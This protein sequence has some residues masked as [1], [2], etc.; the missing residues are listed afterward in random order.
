MN[1]QQ[2][3]S[4]VFNPRRASENR[5]DNIQDFESLSKTFQFT[6]VCEFASFLYGASA[7]V[8]HETNFDEDDGFE[9]P[10]P[11]CREYTLL[12]ANPRSR[13]HAAIPGQTI[14]GPV[15]EVHVAQVF[16]THGR[17]SCSVF[18]GVS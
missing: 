8:K 5:L 14:I 18:I 13:V 1:S 2:V 7:G 15:T 3:I 16:G 10:I 12:Q 11:V 6:N 9:D 17:N 4:L